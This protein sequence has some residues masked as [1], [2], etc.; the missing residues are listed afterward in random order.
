MDEVSVVSALSVSIWCAVTLLGVAPPPLQAEPV[1]ETRQVAP[2]LQP[3]GE[4][5]ISTRADLVS[6]DLRRIEQLIDPTE[7]VLR[8]EGGLNERVADIIS[9][10]Q[11]L[12][13]AVASRISFAWLENQ[14]LLWMQ[15][16]A[17]LS[18]W[19]ELAGERFRTLQGE[20]ERLRDMR[21]L[22]ELTER[23]V[24][25]TELGPELLPRVQGVIARIIDVEARV[26]QRR[27]EV[28]ALADRIGSNLSLVSDAL[29]DLESS[30]GAI[31]RQMLSRD[32]Q[33]LWRVEFGTPSGVVRD[34]R[35]MLGEGW[36]ALVAYSRVSPGA[37]SVALL[38]LL[39]L[40][41][42]ALRNRS[43]STTAAAGEVSERAT[44]LLR[45]RYSV[46][47]AFALAGAY[48]ILPYPI[49]TAAIA[50]V[51]AAAVPLWR[52]GA[53]VF[54]RAARR[55]L[56]A[57][58]VLSL[59]LVATFVIPAG[60]LLQRLT[61]LGVAVVGFV[62][63]S[64]SV[65][66]G[67]DQ[68]QRDVSSLMHQVAFVASCL[69]LVAIVGNLFGWVQLA[70]L[71]TVATVHTLFMAFAGATLV[72]VFSCLLPGI[73]EGRVGDLLPG[74]RR[75][76]LAVERVATRSFALGV[77]A[78]WLYG[79]LIRFQLL[80]PTRAI[81]A[82]V[83]SLG[84]AR[85]G[86]TLSV[87]GIFWAVAILLVTRVLAR[88]VSFLLR[89]ELLPR[90]GL[91]RGDR[92]SVAAVANYLV[93]G[94]GIVI[95]ASAMG[96]GATQL[97]VVI[98]ALSLGIGFGLQTIV[99]NFVS[100]LI[101]IFER[102]IKVGDLLQTV[103]HWGVVKRIGIRASIIR[104]FDGAEIVVPNSDLIAK[105][106]V[107]WTRSD[108]IRRI[109]VLVGVAYGTPPKAVLEILS[110]V[111]R[112]HPIT[113]DDPEPKAQMLSFGESSLEFRLRCWVPI[114][115]WTN[116]ISDLHVAIDEE[117]KKAG[118]TIPFPQRDLHLKSDHR[119]TADPPPLAE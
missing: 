22:W 9:L 10:R 50:F 77:G 108:E 61:I 40:M 58:V 99:N 13:E 14:R 110:S 96:L 109:Q 35:E 55:V 86:L 31:R 57:A 95:A 105:E 8:I 46:A 34:V 48:L 2:P 18:T 74:F 87:G 15:S 52:L 20:R 91:R 69:L 88:F 51:V 47:W 37:T 1:A 28:G 39:F 90:L 66:Y 70:K 36:Q 62:V 75:N 117:L 93:Y 5:D 30:S 106:V 79:S 26:R 11:K 42:A 64:P 116:V 114:E 104:S 72:I 32:E 17:E 16:E 119:D 27:N 23:E 102:P 59:V 115:E 84:F 33:P 4:G 43:R 76:H 60:S 71:L 82:N 41:G 68:N 97:T 111:G 6:A 3:I 12:D 118:I 92:E 65:R 103:D 63:A 94:A 80:E 29:L 67:R 53:I 45:R 7:G 78:Y 83:A 113:L 107:N 38:W 85:G 49:G 21:E 101:L 25:F 112:E 54:D 81:V 100:G 98:G 44:D 19:T 56:Y 73:I 24:D 89:E